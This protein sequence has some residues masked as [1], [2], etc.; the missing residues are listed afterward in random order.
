[1]TGVVT[2]K[3]FFSIWRSF[4]LTKALRVLFTRSKTALE[5]LMR[6]DDGAGT[7]WSG[8]G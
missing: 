8:W 6:D 3:D 4:G 7:A 5:I 1:M 2:K